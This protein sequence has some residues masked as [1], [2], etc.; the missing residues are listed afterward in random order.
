M[1]EDTI[2]KI[3]KTI[4]DFKFLEKFKEFKNFMDIKTL[5]NLGHVIELDTSLRN[6]DQEFIKVL[7]LC[8]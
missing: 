4:E 3:N 5:D 2:K 8:K 7:K 1:V 6:L